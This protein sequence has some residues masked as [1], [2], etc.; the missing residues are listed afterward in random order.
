MPHLI[1]VK[2][3]VC[4]I[5]RKFI[6]KDHR[7]APG[8]REQSWENILRMRNVTC[9]S[10]KYQA[11]Y[12]ACSRHRPSWDCQLHRGLEFCSLYCTWEDLWIKT[13]LLD[14]R[15]SEDKRLLVGCPC[16]ILHTFSLS[17]PSPTHIQRR[18]WQN[19]SWPQTL[20]AAVSPC[21]PSYL[22]ALT[23]CTGFPPLGL[24]VCSL[25]ALHSFHGRRA[26]LLFPLCSSQGRDG[27]W[28]EGSTC[29]VTC[30]SSFFFQ[31]KRWHGILPCSFIL[32]PWSLAPPES[33]ERSW[34]LSA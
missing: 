31:R 28:L 3:S 1:S 23:V 19:R 4:D 12:A 2:C 20:P 29:S 6:V 7:R 16:L 26:R 13:H 24:G 14:L 30:L 5:L 25:C 21:S 15:A 22:L 34:P 18:P 8:L 17:L 32:M 10:L 9:Y 33:P 11:T 27:K